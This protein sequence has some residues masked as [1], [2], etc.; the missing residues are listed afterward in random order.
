MQTTRNSQDSN[1]GPTDWFTGNVYIDAIAT[2]LTAVARRRR[3]RP[4]H[5]GRAHR[6]AHPSLRTDHP[7][8]R[9]AS[10]AASARA[11]RL[12]KIRPGDSVYF[13]PGE[14]HWHGAAANRLMT[15]IAM[16]EADDSGSP[17]AWGRHV[18]DEE[19]GRAPAAY[20]GI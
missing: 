4:F 8:H 12:R 19:Y 7:C 18:T 2:T 13:A 6:V 3:Q 20:E 10:A 17:V 5:P 9:G 14:N 15:H 16:Q 1:P 11:D